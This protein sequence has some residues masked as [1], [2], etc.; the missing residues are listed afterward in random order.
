[1]NPLLAVA[2]SYM[3]HNMEAGESHVPAVSLE[4][5]HECNNLCYQEEADT[6]HVLDIYYPKGKRGCLPLIVDIHGG[7]WIYGDKE[8]NKRYALGLAQAGFAVVNMNY[9]LMPKSDIRRQIQ[10]IFSMFHYLE[11]HGADHHCDLQR[12][13][14]LGDSA[15]AHLAALSY[16]VMSDEELC[17]LYQVTP[18]SFQV[19]A[20][21]SLHGVHDLSFVSNSKRY[22]FRQASDMLHGGRTRKSDL[23]HKAC[24]IDVA[25][26]CSPLP[27]LLVSSQKDVLHV[28][29]IKTRKVLT[30]L[31]WPVE[32]LFWKRSEQLDH[33]FEVNHPDYPESME[34]MKVITAFIKRNIQ[35]L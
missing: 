13:I 14:L 30:S 5:V 25:E 2:M 7:A 10:E 11:V 31:G 8:T 12:V 16:A 26:L 20:L 18:P 17:Q 6:E 33:V 15:G 9:T 28:Q 35:K 19:R 27:V 29:S 3:K 34:T 21:V 4:G 23:Y 32:T 24:L 1:M 22:L